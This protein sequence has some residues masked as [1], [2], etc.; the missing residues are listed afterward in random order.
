M[1]RKILQVFNRWCGS[2]KWFW[3]ITNAA[4]IRQIP[5]LVRNY[6]SCGLRNNASSIYIIQMVRRLMT[7][8]RE[9]IWKHTVVT[10]LV[11]L[12]VLKKIMKTLS[13]DSR[14]THRSSNEASPKHYQT[15]LLVNGE[16]DQK[17]VAVDYLRVHSGT[18]RQ[19]DWDN[20]QCRRLADIW[21]W[22]FPNN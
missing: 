21:T 4:I 19:R 15:A 14:R 9:I 8:K 11:C 2:V 5:R 16:T 12:A 3:E 17:V 6:L 7:E 1:H 22:D 10:I 18:W 13:R 20:R